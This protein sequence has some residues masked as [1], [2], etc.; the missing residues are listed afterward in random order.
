MPSASWSVSA[1][2]AASSTVSCSSPVSCPRLLHHMTMR[3][4]RW[5]M[6]HDVSF[7]HARRCG[8]LSMHSF[9]TRRIHTRRMVATYPRVH[10][11]ADR[12][13]DDAPRFISTRRTVATSDL[14]RLLPHDAAARC[15][16]TL[17]ILSSGEGSVDT[18]RPIGLKSDIGNGPTYR[19]RP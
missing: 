19:T 16:T 9:S 14:P 15:S 8:S 7:T 4:V 12:S 13:L 5:T 1:S 2:I 18:A 10:D 11:D 3:F 17:M 6:H